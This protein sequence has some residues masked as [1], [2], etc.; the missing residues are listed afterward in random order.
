M[1]IS[2]FKCDVTVLIF[3]FLNQMILGSNFEN[4][5]VQDYTITKGD[6]SEEHE[7]TMPLRLTFQ[8]NTGA[9]CR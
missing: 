6:F 2:Q 1:Q 9:H 3:T 7:G 5:V 4:S 8:K